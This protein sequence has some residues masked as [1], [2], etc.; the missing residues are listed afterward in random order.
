MK[1][2]DE[3]RKAIAPKT[4]SGL[5]Q[6]GLACLNASIEAFVYCILGA[7]VNIRSSIIGVGGRAKEAQ[8]EFLVLLEDAIRTPDLAKSVQKY[9][10][11]VDQAKV[12]LNL[13]VAPGAL[14]MP[15]RMIINTQSTIGYNNK[16][17][18]AVLGVIKLGVNNEVNPET[19]KAVLQLM[20][21]GPSKIKP[22]QRAP[23][24][25]T[26][27][28]TEQKAAPTQQTAAPQVLLEGQKTSQHEANK[29]VPIVGA[30]G[31]GVLGYRVCARDVIKFSNPKL[32]SH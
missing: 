1:F 25:Q 15:T 3:R 26:P 2:S 11:A 29:T 23:T 10:L 16:L 7:Q 5:T 32:K 22:Q 6:A 13:A 18:Q 8:L 20:A 28:P 21:G 12:R 27:A 31:V 14:L 17:K 9:Q 24:Q 30:V 4:A 19:K